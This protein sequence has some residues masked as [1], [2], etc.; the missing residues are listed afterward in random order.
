[1]WGSR[2]TRRPHWC[3]CLPAVMAEGAVRLG[4]A[5]R[6]LALLDRIAAI[7]RSVEQLAGQPR[8]HRLLAARAGGGDQPADGERLGALGAHLDRHLVG[9]AADA[10]GADL[11]AR[12]HIVERV[13]EDGERILL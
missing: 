5:M 8:G 3:L 6:V 10:A 7:A 11:D 12:L 2:P 9:R 13:M 4:H 1:M